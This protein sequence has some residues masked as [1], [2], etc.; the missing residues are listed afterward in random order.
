MAKK[1]R[2]YEHHTRNRFSFFAAVLTPQ[3][4]PRFTFSNLLSSKIQTMSLR[5]IFEF[6]RFCDERFC[7]WSLFLISLK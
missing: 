3:G 6:I 5:L 1:G 2:N 7:C 4:W